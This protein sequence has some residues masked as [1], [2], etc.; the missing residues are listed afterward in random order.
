VP[1][2]AGRRRDQQAQ[3]D[4]QGDRNEYVPAHVQNAEDRGGGENA[5]CAIAGRWRWRDGHDSVF[6]NHGLRSALMARAS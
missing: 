2:P 4:G 6:R 3:E 1:Q 5:E